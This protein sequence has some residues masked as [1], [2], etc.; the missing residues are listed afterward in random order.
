MKSFDRL[1]AEADEV[2]E[3]RASSQGKEDLDQ[4]EVYKIAGDLLELK[5]DETTDVISLTEKVA[6]S[7]AIAE[8]FANLPLIRSMIQ[9]EKKALDAGHDPEKI[10]EYLEKNASKSNYISMAEVI[11]WLEAGV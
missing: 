9:F 8:V 4:D 5:N 6:H 7:L 1:I 10:A 2:L 11:P 3:K